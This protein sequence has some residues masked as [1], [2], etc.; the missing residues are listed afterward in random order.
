MKKDTINEKD[1]STM[2]EIV[3]GTKEI[4]DAIGRMKGERQTENTPKHVEVKPSTSNVSQTS[5]TSGLSGAKVKNYMENDA[6]FCSDTG[7]QEVENKFMRAKSHLEYKEWNDAE[8][9]FAEILEIEPNNAGAYMRIFLAK[10]HMA[11]VKK[12]GEAGPEIDLKKE[13]ELLNAYTNGNDNHR[14]FIEKA[15]ENRM[16]QNQYSEGLKK[17][18]TLRLSALEE[19][20]KIFIE[21]DDYL[22]S[23]N[24][25]KKC[26]DEIRKKIVVEEVGRLLAKARDSDATNTTIKESLS[27]IKELREDNK[28]IIGTDLDDS[29]Q[30]LENKVNKIPKVEKFIT[31]SVKTSNSTNGNKI[32]DKLLTGLAIVLSILII[33]CGMPSFK[34]PYV[35]N[36]Y[37]SYL[38]V[39]I[40]G[41]PVWINSV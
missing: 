25:A 33:L 3:S 12:L 17:M 26:R 11:E 20:E 13:K 16:H 35:V 21:L 14:L 24:M 22:D 27:R 18:K 4:T 31:T 9:K 8:R 23:S 5:N 40:I 2:V 15:L 7:S 41:G 1:L 10:S 38:P 34:M 32:I 37:F 39:P 36:N 30:E 6:W 29:I 19:A 28:D